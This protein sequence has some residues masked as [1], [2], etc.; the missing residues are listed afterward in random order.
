MWS[1]Q[2]QETKSDK[3]SKHMDV[4]YEFNAKS[5]NS[6]T[7]NYIVFAIKKRLSDEVN[8]ASQRDSDNF[9]TGDCAACVLL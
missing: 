8:R 9:F 3:Q 2:P 4:R 5:W 6:I 1:A 7:V